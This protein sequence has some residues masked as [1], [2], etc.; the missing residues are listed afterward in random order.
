MRLEYALLLDVRLSKFNANQPFNS[1]CEFGVKPIDG[2]MV[3][4]AQTSL[5]F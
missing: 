4:H 3:P 5:Q 1:P 2:L